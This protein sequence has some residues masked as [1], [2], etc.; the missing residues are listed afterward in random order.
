MSGKKGSA[1]VAAAR[2]KSKAAEQA[3][4]DVTEIEHRL[5]TGHPVAY[6]AGA[7]E[8]YSAFD[9]RSLAL[10]P[11][12]ASRPFW[13]YPNGHVYLE[14]YSSLYS[15]ARDFLVQISEPCSRPIYIHE[16]R[17]SA[18]VPTPQ[19]VSVCACPFLCVRWPNTYL[20]HA[21][22]VRLQ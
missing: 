8:E 7:C 2:G 6:F 4:E 12:H 11:D 5:M 17:C 14:Q 22:V 18:I 10:K 3:I 20:I 13:V 19:C 9:F 15:Q 16:Y 21:S 1:A